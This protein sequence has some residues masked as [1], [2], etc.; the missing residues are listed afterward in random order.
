MES[1]KCL[2]EKSILLLHKN[3]LLRSLIESELTSNILKS[4][5][6]DKDLENEIVKK[7]RTNIGINDE[8]SYQSWLEKSKMKN[9]DFI[10]LA[11]TDIRLKTYSKENFDHQ[12][13]TRFLERKQKL[14]SVVYSLIRIKNIH[15][16]KEIYLRL[17]EK[18]ES[19]RDL[20]TKFSEGAENK[21]GGIIGPVILEKTHPVLAN[22]LSRIK[23]GEV[24]LPIEIDGTYIIVRL[25]SLYRAKLDDFM[26][27]KMLEELFNNWI[28]NK[29]IELNEKIIKSSLKEFHEGDIS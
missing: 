11:L 14:D 16:I 19:F 25:E 8:N 5:K 22:H 24:P 7:F 28:Q 23:P 26:R 1:L 6:L 21:T 12:V 13:E 9:N 29:S 15:K 10:N 20:A 3:N 2:S 17:I 18:E 27:E 4:V